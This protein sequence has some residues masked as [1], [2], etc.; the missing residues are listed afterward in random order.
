MSQPTNGCLAV[1]QK[2]NL[3][4]FNFSSKGVR[5]ASRHI[6]A[7]WAP[8]S[9]DQGIFVA[10]PRSISYFDCFLPSFSMNLA[11]WGKETPNHWRPLLGAQSTPLG[12]TLMCPTTLPPESIISKSSYLR[13]LN[14][15]T[16]IVN[17]RY[18]VEN[19]ANQKRPCRLLYLSA[20]ESS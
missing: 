6:P 7:W 3:H 19:E 10:A 13:G 17:L 4:S 1:T 2:L 18:F 12:F 15:L 8:D 16:D 20:G 9:P 14:A 11:N 5:A